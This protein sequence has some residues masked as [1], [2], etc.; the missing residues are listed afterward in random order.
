LNTDKK[1]GIRVSSVATF[2]LRLRVLQS[3][4]HPPV[5]CGF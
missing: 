2:L 3:K 1:S 4:M 5:W